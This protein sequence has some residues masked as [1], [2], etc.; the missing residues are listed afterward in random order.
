MR[1]KRTTPPASVTDIA[2]LLLL[3]FL[4][5]A[6]TTKQS[7][8]AITPAE[9]ETPVLEQQEIPTLLVTKDGQLYFAGNP[10][11]VE[12][13]TAEP[14]YAILSD[15][16]TPYAILHPIMQA[17]RELGVQELHCLVQEQP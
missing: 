6:V 14:T 11:T 3:F 5:L 10:T 17:L 1:K 7:P 16:E 13:L 2:F 8:K 15:K 4:I 12:E 9:A